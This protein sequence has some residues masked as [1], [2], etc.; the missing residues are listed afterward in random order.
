MERIK[1]YYQEFVVDKFKIEEWHNFLSKYSFEDVNRKLDEHLNSETYGNYIPKINF[2]TKFLKT[3]EEKENEQ[4]VFVMCPF[5]KKSL[6]LNDYSKHVARHNSVNYVKS[7]EHFLRKKHDDQKLLNA[8][9]FDF[10]VFY[11]CFLEELY[12]KIEDEDEKHRLKNIIYARNG[13]EI[14]ITERKIGDV[15][16]KV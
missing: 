16:K 1:S 9:E 5:C 11:N 6:S 8:N 7:R 10:E 2:L 15:I 3:E 4:E 12:E 13:M 14:E